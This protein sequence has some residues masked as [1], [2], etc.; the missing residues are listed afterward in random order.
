MLIQGASWMGQQYLVD[1]LLDYFEKVHVQ[2][3]DLATLVDDSTRV[4]DYSGNK[5][6]VSSPLNSRP[7]DWKW[8]SA[9]VCR[10]QVAQAECSTTI[11]PWSR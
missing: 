8:Y 6:L 3:F 10:G 2:M 7:G 11:H 4:G 9:V 1:A 5:V